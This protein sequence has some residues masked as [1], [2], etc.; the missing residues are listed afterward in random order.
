MDSAIFLFDRDAGRIVA[1]SE[2]HS[3]RVTSILFHPKEDILFSTSYD[4]TARIWQP[5]EEG[6][7][8]TLIILESI[9]TLVQLKSFYLY[10]KFDIFFWGG[11][12]LHQD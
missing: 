12:K 7:Y 2:E 6:W 11:V 1:S 8:Q 5:L 3:K 4:H 10:S 9:K